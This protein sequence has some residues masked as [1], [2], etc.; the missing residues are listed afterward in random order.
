MD[1]A[2]QL[3]PA[4]EQILERGQVELT[5][6]EHRYVGELGPPVE[7]QLL[8]RDDVGVMLHF[9]QDDE[10]AG[11]DIGAAPRVG[12]Q[13]DGR[14]GV[15]GE[16]RLLGGRPQPR[17]D[18]CAGALKQLSRLNG[19]RVHATV[20]RG[21]TLGVVPEH[22]VD[23]RLWGLRG[24]GGVQVADRLSVE[25]APQDRELSPDVTHRFDGRHQRIRKGR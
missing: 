16:D 4:G 18:P 3:G 17:R 2:D 12:D 25:L 9:G 24:G 7:A 20:D 10:I 14:G 22:R 15:G 5:V 6:V 23:D 19:E 1:H 13:V 8:P 21:A 11:T